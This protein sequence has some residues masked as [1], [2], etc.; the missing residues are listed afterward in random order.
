MGY[1][2][3]MEMADQAQA[4]AVAGLDALVFTRTKLHAL[5]E[6][7]LAAELHGATGRIGLRATHGGFGQ[8]ER[9]DDHGVRRR[10]RISGGSLVV[11]D[12][13]TETWHPLTTLGDAAEAAG[14]D[15]SAPLDA[16]TA[17]SHSDPVFDV[18]P[19]PVAAADLADWF[20]FVEDALELFRSR[21]SELSPTVVQLWPEHFDLA[22]SVAEINFGGSPGDAGG[23]GRAEPYLYVGPWTP[24]E[25]AFWNE[26]YGA[27]L[28]RAEVATVADALHFFET[29]L[30]EATA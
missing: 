14:V 3:R 15:L 7:V 21:H 27:A 17:T 28:G 4:A 9:L 24:R 13:D 10:L 6:R 12:G 2:R 30:A 26:P 20:A 1:Q 25:G 11:T 18:S 22:C 29:G 23:E 19:D 16:Y 8:P 5:A